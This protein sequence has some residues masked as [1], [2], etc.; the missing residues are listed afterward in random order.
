VAR[1]GSVRQLRVPGEAV[2]RAFEQG[3]NYLYWGSMRRDSFGAALRRLS[4]RRD[5]FALVIQSYT[6]AAS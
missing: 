6:R 5:Q 1:A 4:S 3:V 2:E